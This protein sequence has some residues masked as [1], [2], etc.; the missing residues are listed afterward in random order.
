[1]DFGPAEVEGVVARSTHSIAPGGCAAVSCQ[2][3]HCQ[4]S[5]GY[6]VC[7]RIPLTAGGWL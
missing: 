6:Q 5:P 4:G 1:M 2:G 3:C 7:R